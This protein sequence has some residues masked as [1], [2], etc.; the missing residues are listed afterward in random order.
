[1]IFWHNIHKNGHFPIFNQT[2][3]YLGYFAPR[4][5]RPGQAWDQFFFVIFSHTPQEAL[6]KIFWNLVHPSQIF[7]K[8]EINV[9]KLNFHF[10][11]EYNTFSKGIWLFQKT[12]EI[13]YTSWDNQW[14]KK[15]SIWLESDL[16]YT[17]QLGIVTRFARLLASAEISMLLKNLPCMLSWMANSFYT[18]G[19]LLVRENGR[20]RSP[21]Y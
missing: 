5:S 20:L 21:H 6:V 7:A 18:P 14:L 16:I 12:F 8:I 10:W 9:P 17:K 1:M 15:I 11:V 3:L 19:P 4:P 2:G 13:E